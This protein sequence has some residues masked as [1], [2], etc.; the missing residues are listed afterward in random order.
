ME[1]AAL[2]IAIIGDEAGL[3]V[4][5]QG[6][7]KVGHSDTVRFDITQPG[8]A[9]ELAK[10]VPD[11]IVVAFAAPHPEQ[12]SDVMILVRAIARPVALFVAQSD[13]AMT[14]AAVNA[15]VS[16]YV[17]DGLRAD[18]IKPV[19]D[20]AVE[21]F[22]SVASMQKQLDEARAALAERR[23]I[24][25]AKI[26]LMSTRKLTEANAYALLR[27]TAMRQGK[28]IVDIAQALLTAAELLEAK[29]RQEN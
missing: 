1:N 24:D 16:A 19:L 3:D 13:P 10:E 7:R 29:T 25:R 9:A 15:G 12:W 28:R 6:L 18:R 8:I 21:R 17:V 23:I 4:A 5:E 20:L 11:A 22:Q 26:Y 2:R 14:A 27:G